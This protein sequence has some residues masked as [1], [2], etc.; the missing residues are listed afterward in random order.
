MNAAAR[1][2]IEPVILCGD[3]RRRALNLFH[4]GWGVPI[5]AKRLRVKPVLVSNCVAEARE[6]GDPRATRRRPAS[7]GK[8]A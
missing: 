4:E 3:R 8:P 5:I 2:V 6:D 7:V 1:V